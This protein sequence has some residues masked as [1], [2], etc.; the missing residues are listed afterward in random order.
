[1][2]LIKNFLL[3]N[4]GSITLG[5]GI[6]NLSIWTF[7]DPAIYFLVTGLLLSAVGMIQILSEGFDEAQ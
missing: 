6:C 5:L 7:A 2:Q 1:M 4:S 3:R